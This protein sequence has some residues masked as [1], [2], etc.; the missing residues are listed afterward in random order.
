MPE[1]FDEK[2]EI[3]QGLSQLGETTTAG[4]LLRQ[5][6]QTKKL[7][8]ISEKQLMEWILQLLR[9]HMAGKA[10]AYT[11]R[12]KSEL[13]QK[14][15][16]ELRR[17]IQ[18]EQEAQA[19][20]DRL[21]AELEQA[22][23]ALAQHSASRNQADIE[24][25][26][27]A[28]RQK[29]E[30]TEQVNLDLQ[31][32]NYELQDQLNEKMALLSTTIAEKDKL[33]ET[34]RNQMRRMAALCEGVIGLD[35]EYYGGRHQ[36]ENPVS[37]DASDD[38]QFYHDFDVG[39]KVIVTLKNDLERLRAL[40]RREEERSAEEAAQPKLLE[41]DLALLAELK[42]G[43]LKAA[44]VAAPIAGLLE[45]LDGAR[46]E[47]V[48][49]DQALA[50]AT[51][52]GQTLEP[53][54]TPEEGEQPAE[55]LVAATNLVR[56][57]TA[58]LARARGRIAALKTMADDSDTARNAIEQELETL[59][60]AFDRLCHSVRQRAEAEH[61]AAPSSLTDSNATPEERAAA[62]SEV[63][64][65]LQAAS[66]FESAVVEQLALTDRLVRKGG[67]GSMQAASP[68]DKRELADR[69]RMAGAELE[70]Y[71]MD[72]QRQ[73][74]EA[75]A[76]ERALAARLAELAAQ[77]GKQSEAAAEVQRALSMPSADAAALT[78]AMHRAL[79]AVASE[80]AARADALAEDRLLTN[81]LVQACT[82]DDTLA[83]RIADLAIAAETSDPNT[84]PQL[85]EQLRQAVAALGERRQQLAERERALSAEVAQLRAQVAS[86]ASDS[87]RQAQSLQA[88]QSELQQ[89][90]REAQRW[91]QAYQEARSALDA[92]F[93]ALQQQVPDTASALHES[94][95]APSTRAA[96]AVEAVQRLAAPRPVEQA[97]WE[98]MP[99][100]ERSAQAAG[101]PIPP[102]APAGDQQ[103]AAARL[104]SLTLAL[105]A[106]IAD[107]QRELANARIR[108]RDLAR[109]VRELTAAF[110]APL[111]APSW[112][113]P[114][115]P[116]GSTE[117]LVRQLDQALS[118]EAPSQTVNEAA[119]RALAEL[120]QQA[121]ANRAEAA[122][123][124]EQNRALQ[125]ALDRLTGELAQRSAAVGREIPQLRDPALPPEV[126]AAAAQAA[127]GQLTERHPVEE[128]ARAH[129]EAVDRVLAA[130]GGPPVRF[131]EGVRPGDAPA[132]AARVR[133][134][135]TAL[136]AHV[137]DLAR[138]LADA[139][140]RER[141]LARQVRELTATLQA[142]SGAAAV[143]NEALQRL[144]QALSAQAPLEVVNRALQQTLADLANSATQARTAPLRALA[145]DMIQAARQDPVLA[146]QTVELARTVERPQAEPYALET[147]MRAA[148]AAMQG[149]QQALQAECDRL[150]AEVARLEQLRNE[151]A[152]EAARLANEAS[153]LKGQNTA[154]RTALD[155]LAT[156]VAQRAAA[157]GQPA[158][159]VLQD[160]EAAPEARA[161]AVLAAVSALTDRSPLEEAA[162]NHLQL[163][164]RLLATTGGPSASF[165]DALRG[166]SDP[167]AIAT[168]L[169]DADT[170]LNQ[171]VQGLARELDQAQQRERELLRQLR[172]LAGTTTAV[173]PH[174]IPREDLARLE[175]ALAEPTT[176]PAA[177]AV[178]PIVNALK[179][180]LGQAEQQ[181]RTGVMR[182]LADEL[183]KAGQNDPNLAEATA[184]LAMAVEANAVE[185]LERE[186]REA[187]LK[188]A[189]RKRQLELD[190]TRFAIEVEKA[191][192]ER[193]A[194][195]RRAD[196]A[197]RQRMLESERLQAEI[198]TLKQEL[199]QAQADAQE[200]RARNEATG[201]QF[202]SEILSLRQELGELRTRYQEQGSLLATLRQQLEAAEV[203]LKRQ[204]E[205]LTRGLEERDALIAEKDRIID[206][207]TTQRIDAKAL[208]AKIQVLSV[209]LDAANARIR[210]LEERTGEQAGAAVRSGDMAELHK[211]TMAE[212][213]QLREQKR[214]LEAEL[215]DARATIEQMSLEV[216]E[217]R[218][219]YKAESEAHA[220][221]V[222]NLQQA[223][224]SL[225]DALRKLHEEVAG[226]KARLRRGS[227]S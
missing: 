227:E 210:E 155:Q 192:A 179:S 194:A 220:R 180:Y 50:A 145:A 38:E 1:Q 16:E 34:V 143:S 95:G 48:A 113:A 218:R 67:A 105:E 103:Q 190:R 152:Q 106:R 37:E 212:R 76:R 141:D 164:E 197:E 117:Q 42:Q 203:R 195:L 111:A 94:S 154:L 101:A 186:L 126:K 98:S 178:K 107:L 201:S 24:A 8:V 11:D 21:K 49:C 134:S 25:A 29:L 63:L 102:S 36:Q 87:G 92:V 59:R 22:M 119:T 12:E 4:E 189:A 149:R 132:V 175:R 46:S 28:L 64:S 177:E 204:R 170:V 71:T 205:E 30:E 159:S 144:D 17:R 199:E 2:T 121:Q 77:R 70:R 89:V 85:S 146:E 165:S 53:A 168:K 97:A 223:N 84:Q 211:R 3:A 206:Q 26:L 116:A 221:D 176:V 51:G 88:L 174:A 62:A 69:L 23:Q 225:K 161:K 19:E 82:G 184:P 31:Q 78:Q 13:L 110:A 5:K 72:L 202:S 147:Q 207:L 182:S 52:S 7:R 181:T 32:D 91:Q 56:E 6:G 213:D 130:T 167:A 10:D 90:Q 55:T 160:P 127:L 100:L 74:D 83:D 193:A 75:L 60:S 187:L 35:N 219:S 123:L 173:A 93:A 57:L 125:A 118:S 79:D 68:R 208:Q 104:R 80:A 9:Q 133:E 115:P 137:R 135:D 224:T 99:V 217:L 124:A 222:A 156:E 108:E 226:I 136:E 142:A 150:Q 216:E 129:L 114:A 47:V 151:R 138:K 191:K 66:P 112:A 33:R 200:F 86:M 166:N 81:A 122:R 148:I 163:A 215:A 43:S 185:Q 172:E 15:Q 20:R 109:Q 73:L 18:R 140:R 44:D 27:A 198:A 162:R 169:R 153:R 188:L 209:E 45:A 39:A 58:N 171:H 157:S 158:A 61:L 96:A 120:A 128:A 139:E 14:A 196:E 41:S 65:Q 40:V 131:S 214:R 183:L 54:P